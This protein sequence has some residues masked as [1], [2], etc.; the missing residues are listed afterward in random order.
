MKIFRNGFITLLLSVALVVGFAVLR[1]SDERGSFHSTPERITLAAFE[2]HQDRVPLHNHDPLEGQPEPNGVYGPTQGWTMDRESTDNGS[3]TPSNLLTAESQVRRSYMIAMSY[4]SQLTRAIKNLM[5]H[6]CWARNLVKEATLVEPFSSDSALLHTPDIWSAVRKDELQYAA[7]FSD[8]FDLNFYNQASAEQNGAPLIVWEEFLAKAPRQLVVVHT[9]LASCEKLDKTV[10]LKY[11]KFIEALEALDFVVV[12]TV[13]IDCHNPNRS[14]VKELTPYLLT[15]TIAFSS[16]RNYAIVGTWFKVDPACDT[17]TKRPAVRLAPSEKI[18]KHTS[19]YKAFML[20]ANK[21][22]AVMLRVER[23]LTLLNSGLTNETV[24]SCLKR[25]VSLFKFLKGQAQWSDSKPYLTL[26]IG[27]FGSGVMQKTPAVSKL[28]ASLEKV[29]DL[30]TTT[31]VDV[32]DGQW[33]SIAE[34]ENSFVNVTHIEER[35]YIA[36]LQREIAIHSDCLILMGGGSYQEVA[37]SR[38]LETHPHKPCL[39]TVCSATAIPT[40]L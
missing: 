24:D 11:L 18:K 5:G 31:L 4:E 37:A 26:D 7:R 36:M 2:R 1:S 13:T 6:Q 14:L 34:W 10:N 22:I 12:K 30:V 9:P 17:S 40:S 21:V 3:F 39:Y 23:F 27:R 33:Q 19:D 20:G 25:T 38:Y 8:Y 16:W 28:G 29:T 15:A 32:C 35:G